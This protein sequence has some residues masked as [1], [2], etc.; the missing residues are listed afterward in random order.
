MKAIPLT[1]K[2]IQT[3]KTLLQTEWANW[4]PTI[5]FEEQLETLRFLTWTQNK[6]QAP[7]P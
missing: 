3:A 7:Q 5:L 4:R 6:Q 2:H 1:N